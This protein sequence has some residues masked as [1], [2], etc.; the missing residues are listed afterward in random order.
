MAVVG[1]AEK[2]VASYQKGVMPD[3]FGPRVVL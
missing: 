2:E 1:D 3:T